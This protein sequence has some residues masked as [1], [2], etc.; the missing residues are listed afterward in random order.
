MGF[1]YRRKTNI[2]GVTGFGPSI[3]LY[4]DMDS[5]LKWTNEGSGNATLAKDTT[6][7]YTGSNSL[8]V[9]SDQGSIAMGDTV[10][11]S[12]NIVIRPG[13]I[14]K[15]NQLFLQTHTDKKF[16]LEWKFEYISNGRLYTTSLTYFTAQE[17]WLY[18]D[19]NGDYQLV[20]NITH[21]LADNKW[22]FF[23]LLFNTQTHKFM[24]FT[25]DNATASI[26]NIAY[27]NEA[28][29]A[30]PYGKFTFLGTLLVGVSH[31]MT[32]RMDNISIIAE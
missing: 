12:R 2:E 26:N 1:P 23:E 4:D 8:K 11:A 17:A 25:I 28:D 15:I 3:L 13:G 32:I 31:F 19:A 20:P 29:A 7:V 6:V 30:D 18:L 16:I 21:T 22:H 5:T 24:S 9:T 14:I 27:K 10:G